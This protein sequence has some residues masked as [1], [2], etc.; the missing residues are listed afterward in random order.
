[1]E[2]RWS[3]FAPASRR[4]L[5]LENW[6]RPSPGQL[7]AI[8]FST[9][10]VSLISAQTGKPVHRIRSP[11]FPKASICCLGWGLNFTYKNGPANLGTVVD[12]DEV[13]SRGPQAQP[14]NI[15]PDLPTELAFLDVEGILPRLSTLPAGGKGC[16]YKEA[17][18]QIL[19][20]ANRSPGMS[21]SVQERH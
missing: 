3:A 16:V 9:S 7:L 17:S 1:M 6:L 14:S 2:T 13:L 12:L 19:A 5:S 11:A 8:A 15:P 4:H 21:C 20:P 10:T 18:H